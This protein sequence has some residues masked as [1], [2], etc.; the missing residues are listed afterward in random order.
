MESQLTAFALGLFALAMLFFD[1]RE[2]KARPL[3]IL[4]VPAA[5]FFATLVLVRDEFFA[6]FFSLAALS[7]AFGL[8]LYFGMGR[9]K[10]TK[11][12]KNEKGEIIARGSVFYVVFWFAVLVV[13]ASAVDFLQQN[14]H[15]SSALLASILLLFA[16]GS[17]LGKNYEV[18]RKYL[19]ARKAPA[20]AE[21]PAEQKKEGEN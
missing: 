13:K 14:R 3:W 15:V 5:V 4:L 21:E 11:V 8:G 1:V 2:K 12:E 20:P 17:L 9:G 16:C 19:G 18:L 10:L 6:S 7:F